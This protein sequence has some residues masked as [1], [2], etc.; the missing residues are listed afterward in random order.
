M[1][2]LS[3]AALALLAGA[4]QAQTYTP[5]QALTDPGLVGNTQYDGW[6]GLT[7]SNYPGFGG[8]PGTS[9]WPGAIG[10][11][12]TADNQFNAAEPGDAELVKVAN[13]NGGGPYL[14]GGSIYFGGFS[15]D[16]NNNGGTLAVTDTTP[17]DDLNNVVFQIQIGEA[18]TFDFLDEALPT[19]SYNGGD[20][21]LAATTTL[22]TERFY[23]GTVDMP[24][25]PEDVFINT[26]MLQWDLTGVAEPITDFSVEFTAVQHAQLY[27]LQ[28]DQSD[29]YTPVPTPGALACAAAA[30]LIATRRRRR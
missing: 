1:R 8:F 6:I 18:W 2:V 23:N 14:A 22:I 9:D 17:V 13:G 12:R 21:Q 26:Y 24:T 3:T 5:G 20:Q 28:L 27:G 15:A 10:S 30:G 4:A 7:S 29:V 16:I 11:N 25:G 19:L